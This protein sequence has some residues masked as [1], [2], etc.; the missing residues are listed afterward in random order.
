MRYLWYIAQALFI[1]WLAHGVW[2]SNPNMKPGEL[3]VI[4]GIAIALC[5]FL[6]ACITQ[7]WDWAVRRLRRTDRNCG[8]PGGDGL[9]LTG[10]WGRSGERTKQPKRIG[11]R[12]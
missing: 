10:T 7:S 4:L 12:D 8:Q 2:D 5:A 6:T 9:R 1:G 11:V 3:V